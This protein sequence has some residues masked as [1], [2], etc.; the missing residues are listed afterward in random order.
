MLLLEANA[1]KLYWNL[2]KQITHRDREWGRVYPGAK[3]QCN[4]LL[5]T[6]YTILKRKCERVI[7]DAGLFPHI[8]I[9]HTSDRCSLVYDFMEI[10]RHVAVDSVIVPAFSRK[11][12]NSELT[13]KE[14]KKYFAMLY[15]KYNQSFYY[16]GRLEK[17][18]SIMY[19]EAVSLRESIV[20]STEWMPYRHRFG[21]NYANKKPLV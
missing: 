11:K 15:Q 19:R 12:Y 17:L 2:F 21:N 18:E 3:D 6:G 7:V 9:F 16:K 14:M 13:E 5:N 10:F 4:I 20:H 8:G 1:G